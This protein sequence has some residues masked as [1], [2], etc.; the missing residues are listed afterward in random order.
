MTFS[1]QYQYRYFGIFQANTDIDNQYIYLLAMK[2]CHYFST[3]LTLKASLI[4]IQRKTIAI[5]SHTPVLFIKKT[6]KKYN[7][8]AINSQE[9]L[10]L[11]A[12]INSLR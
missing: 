9:R 11:L 7:D 1:G 10:C 3:N 4:P 12:K 5:T 2:F 8:L 6:N